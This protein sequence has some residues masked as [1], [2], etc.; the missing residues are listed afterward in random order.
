MWTLLPPEIQDLIWSFVHQNL[1]KEMIQEL[2]SVYHH[3]LIRDLA[4]SSRSFSFLQKPHG[5]TAF[6]NYTG[7]QLFVETDLHVFDELI[8]VKRMILN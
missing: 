7:D 8:S 3:T 6:Y 5:R 1:M 4:D 2:N